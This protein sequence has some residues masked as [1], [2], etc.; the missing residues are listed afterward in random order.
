MIVLSALS[1]GMGPVLAPAA[2]RPQ[3]TWFSLAGSDFNPVTNS[4]QTMGVTVYVSCADPAVLGFR[5][6][7]SVQFG[8]G[9]GAAA[10]SGTAANVMDGDQTAVYIPIAPFSSQLAFKTRWIILE[11]FR[12]DG[13]VYTVVEA[14]PIPNKI[15]SVSPGQQA[16]R[17]VQPASAGH[18]SP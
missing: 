9:V 12:N 3:V 16:P 18:L 17:R 14:A 1:I 13:G 7:A 8:E 4:A 6:T 11:V 2:D 15:Y 5:A 10:L